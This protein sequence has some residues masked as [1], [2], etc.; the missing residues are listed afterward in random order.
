MASTSIFQSL[1]EERACP[2]RVEDLLAECPT[3]WKRYQGFLEE[4]R[5]QRQAFWTDLHRSS[6]PDVIQLARYLETVGGY[7]GAVREQERERLLA[8]TRKDAS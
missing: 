3:V 8:A 2:K 7:A 6:E 5:T 4:L 1:A